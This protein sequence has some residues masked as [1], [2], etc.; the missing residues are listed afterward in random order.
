MNYLIA[1][2]VLH[3][4]IDDSGK[5]GARS[6]RRLVDALPQRLQPVHVDDGGGDGDD[7][8][9][10]GR[11]EA[12]AAAQLHQIVVPVAASGKQ[13][14]QRPSNDELKEKKNGR[15]ISSFCLLH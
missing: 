1:L 14:D 10:H 15:E 8:A 2:T 4:W 5:A 11:H 9:E 7:Y 13:D 12:E 6:R 3:G